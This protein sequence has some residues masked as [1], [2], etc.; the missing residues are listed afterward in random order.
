M[1][2]AVEFFLD[3]RLLLRIGP[4]NVDV[5][6]AELGQLA[7]VQHTPHAHILRAL[8]PLDTALD[9]I[10]Q[11]HSTV[12]A[13]VVQFLEAV[14]VQQIDIIVFEG[15]DDTQRIG[16][17]IVGLLHDHV[18]EL[19]H[20]ITFLR[21]ARIGGHH[22]ADDDVGMEVVHH[23]IRREVVVDTAVVG[24]HTV[25]LNGFEH[26]R[27]AHRSPHGI[28]HIA[29]AHDEGTLVVHI[30]SH[31]TEGN[32]QIVEIAPTGR[33]SLGIK[34]HEHQIHLNG[35]HQIGRNDLR[36][37]ADGIAKSKADIGKFG[38][39]PVLLEVIFVAR[40]HFTGIPPLE[41]GRAEQLFHI[42][43]RIAH[44]IERPDDG[45]HGGAR[46]VVDGDVVLFQRTDDADV[47]HTLG[48]AATQ[49][50]SHLLGP[51]H[52]KQATTQQKDIYFLHIRRQTIVIS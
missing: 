16:N 21:F 44:G 41:V 50:E 45:A 30:R 48:T 32:K 8:P 33:C 40:L 9:G 2:V 34:L 13:D 52:R 46:D 14:E 28:A 20:Q 25:Y 43:G 35:V 5:A 39:R 11:A 3:V 1:V 29:V 23:D 19:A 49:H 47:G 26:K 22:T 6:E 51:K 12:V 10:H 17:G 7:A 31:T 24:Q 27:E 37:H 36:L 42:V 4:L 18:L 38:R 15:H